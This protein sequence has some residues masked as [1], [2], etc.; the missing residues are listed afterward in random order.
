MSQQLKP[1]SLDLLPAVSLGSK[2]TIY[3][4]LLTES[5]PSVLGRSSE[6]ARNSK[7]DEPLNRKTVLEYREVAAWH[8]YILAQ[9]P[10]DF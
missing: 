8:A 5:Q 7:A 1:Q 3:T 2:G 4:R 10:D 9:L 6:I